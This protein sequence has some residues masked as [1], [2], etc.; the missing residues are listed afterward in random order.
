MA[1]AHG[2]DAERFVRE[3][4]VHY[5]VRTDEIGDR[6]HREVVGFEVR[7]F[8][9]RGEGKLQA[10]ACDESVELERDLRS[11]AEGLIS[12]EVAKRA[13]LVP[14]ATPVLY[15]S[16]EVPGADE[17]EVTMRVLCDAHGAGKEHGEQCLGE[18]SDHLK[19]A[20]VPRR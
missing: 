9:T 10:P 12:G 14:A 16:S 4:H 2:G 20:G 19:A 7:L 6:D 1:Q 18:L 5:E 3:H 13:E 8:A 17:V 11:F 15:A